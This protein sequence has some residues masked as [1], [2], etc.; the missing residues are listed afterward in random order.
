MAAFLSLGFQDSVMTLFFILVKGSSSH[1][2]SRT[3]SENWYLQFAFETDQTLGQPVLAQ[4]PLPGKWDTSW[5]F[6]IDFGNLEDSKLAKQ[7]ILLYLGPI[8]SEISEYREELMVVQNL[9][10]DAQG[11]VL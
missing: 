8:K 7:V 1:P 3:W 6:A 2:S 11:P 4:K 9:L 5:T 10:F